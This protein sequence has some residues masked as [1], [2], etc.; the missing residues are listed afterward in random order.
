MDRL[1]RPGG[2]GGDMNAPVAL[3]GGGAFGRSAR[4]EVRNP[5]LALPAALAVLELPAEQRRP[6]GI[7]LRELAAQADRQAE[8][9][10]RKRKG[11]AAA[12]WRAV[13]IYAKHL[14]RAID[15]RSRGAH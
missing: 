6:L 5:V 2:G 1:S 8:Q 10:W 3:P 4:R 7:L 12:Y 11:M 13:S 14:A 9:S 15:P